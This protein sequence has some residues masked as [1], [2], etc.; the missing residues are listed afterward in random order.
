[1]LTPTHIFFGWVRRQKAFGTLWQLNVHISVTK[2]HIFFASVSMFHDNNLVMLI[3]TINC[4]F[5]IV[6][7]FYEILLHACVISLI[8]FFGK[9]SKV[10][11]KVELFVFRYMNI[12]NAKLWY[13]FLIEYL[14]R[15]CLNFQNIVLVNGQSSI[16]CHL[17]WWKLAKS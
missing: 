2:I 8:C 3:V 13:D 16:F 5:K 10:M 17:E 15:C 4:Y 7:K 1:M 6:T 12:T 11:S 9:F 14:L